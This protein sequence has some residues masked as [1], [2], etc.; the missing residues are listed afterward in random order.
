MRPCVVESLTR[1]TQQSGVTL[2]LP[3]LSERTEENVGVG[4]GGCGGRGCCDAAGAPSARMPQ[5]R[6][7]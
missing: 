4:V 3:R 2:S 5:V 1:Q 7:P 6:Q